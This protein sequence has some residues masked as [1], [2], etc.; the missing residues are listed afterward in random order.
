M[1]GLVKGIDAFQEYVGRK[2][3]DDSA[4]GVKQIHAE[5][6]RM[7]RLILKLGPQRM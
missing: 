7:E 4:V 5:E 1:R 3:L 2:P 6:Q